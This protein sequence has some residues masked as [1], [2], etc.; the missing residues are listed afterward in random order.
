MADLPSLRALRY[1]QQAALH[2]SFSLAAQSLNVTHSAIS[3]QIKQLEEWLGKPLFV[4]ANGRVY[5]TADGERLKVTC[6]RAF[7][8]IETTC[9]KI[10]QRT[11]SSLTVSSAPSFLSQWL[12]PRISHFSQQHPDISLNFQTHMDIDKVRSDQTDVLILSHEQTSHHDIA[13]TLITV[14]YI[15]PVCS[16]DFDRQVSHDTDF[17]TLPLLHAE[18]KRHA[19]AEWAEKSGARGDFWAGRY[20][21]NLTLGIQAA[22]NGL[23]LMITPRILVKKELEDGTLI[24][25]VGFTAMARATWMMVKQS[26]KDEQEIAIFRRWLLAEAAGGE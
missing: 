25:P 11:S 7:S 2:N 17:T 1:F 9:E 23:G 3:H 6:T 13:A 18:T 22:R 5:L 12:I 4:R 10:S 19:W 16:A 26:R 8:E 24:A 15:G 21:D 20:F 14:D